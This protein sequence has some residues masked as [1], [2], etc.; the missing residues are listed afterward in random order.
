MN[1]GSKKEGEKVLQEDQE[2]KKEGRRMTDE[3]LQ[4]NLFQWER[5]PGTNLNGRLRS[6][7]LRLLSIHTKLPSQGIIEEGRKNRRDAFGKAVWKEKVSAKISKRHSRQTFA[8]QN[9]S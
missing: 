4:G 1:V 3:K 7:G 5:G 8:R 2:R 9:I 6:R